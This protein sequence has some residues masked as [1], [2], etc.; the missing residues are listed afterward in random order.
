MQPSGVHCDTQTRTMCSCTCHVWCL[1]V[2]VCLCVLCVLARTCKQHPGAGGDTII[3][4]A[5][6]HG[7][8]GH[9]QCRRAS[10]RQVDLGSGSLA[11][12]CLIYSLTQESRALPQE[13]VAARERL[14]AAVVQG[15]RA[16]ARRRQPA[17]RLE[18]ALPMLP[19]GRLNAT[20]PP[21]TLE[22]VAAWWQTCRAS[23]RPE[24]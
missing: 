20:N 14:P 12:R 18:S 15:L 3:C 10:N 19:A 2:C 17:P 7:S 24:C 6:Q 9:H 21:Q 16:V 23:V 5:H 13:L 22:R 8:A 4:G 11:P 1:S